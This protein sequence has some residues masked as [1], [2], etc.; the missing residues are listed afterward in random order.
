MNERWQ[1]RT[2][3]GEKGCTNIYIQHI[4]NII[5]APVLYSTNRS[6][7]SFQNEDTKMCYRAI[8]PMDKKPRLAFHFRTHV[9]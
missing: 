8:F 6:N 2:R 4:F 7:N 5:I 3:N 1:V 9:I